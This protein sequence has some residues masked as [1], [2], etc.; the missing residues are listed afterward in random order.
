VFQRKRPQG[1]LAMG[2][3]SI[4]C[5]LTGQ[6]E[7]LPTA[8]EYP[9][10][11]VR[12]ISY[13]AGGGRDW[14]LSA[15]WTPR[16]EPAPWKMVVVTGAPSWS[17]YWTPVM[18]ALPKDREMLVVDR[19]G[20]SHSE[21]HHCVPEIEVQAE[22]L[23]P[24]LQARPGQKV[25]LVGQ[26]YGAAIATLMASKRPDLVGALAL[27]SGFFG[28]P[29]PTARFW[30]NIGS[31]ILSVIPRDLKHAVMEVTGQPSQLNPV[32]KLLAGRPF[33]ITFVHG[34]K[35][36][37]APIEVARRAAQMTLAP[38]RF[39]EL[40]GA[41]HFLNDGPPERLIYCLETAIRGHGA[42]YEVIGPEPAPA[43]AMALAS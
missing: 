26:S 5:A 37:F 15:L 8:L 17:E 33:L 22:A 7:H 39:I 10:D 4:G 24:A 40:T 2:L 35:D 21:P 34:D 1:V 23:L 19:P 13:Q 31:K 43:E 6:A 27:V 42:L 28:H 18:A 29:G 38:S 11:V 9:E 16:E 20:F 30:V 12:R 3:S 25:L 41:D 32:F 14:K 36:D